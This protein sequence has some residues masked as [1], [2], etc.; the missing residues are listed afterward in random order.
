VASVRV[1]PAFDPFERCCG[2]LIAGVP[3]V[4]VEEFAL[5]PGEERLGNRIV[6][7]VTDRA[8]RAKQAGVA[9][10]VAEEP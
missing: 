7:A 9:E 5:E 1:V 10:P 8:H 6:E 4:L 2:E 3:I